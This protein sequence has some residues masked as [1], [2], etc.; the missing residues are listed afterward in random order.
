MISVNNLSLYFGGQ[1]VFKGISLSVNKGDKIGLVGKNGAGKSTLLNLFAQKIN[2]NSGNVAS[3]NNLKIGY[4]TQDLDFVD[5]LSV[6]DEAKKAYKEIN[7]LQDEIVTL[8]QELGNRTDYESEGY[9]QLISHLHEKQEQFR[10]KG[11]HD[12]Q[13]SIT[14]VLLGLGFL[15][16]DFNRLTNEFSGGWRMRIELAKILLQRPDVLLLDEPTNHLD[17]ESIIWLENWLKKF[18]GALVLVSHDRLFL[19]SVT[20]RTVEI[21]FGRLNQYK[22][23]YTKYI[24]LRKDRQ[25]KQIQAKKNQDK[26]IDETKILINKFRAK[27]NKAAF[28]QTL[29]KKLEKLEIIEVEQEDIAK[30]RFKFP[31]APHSGKVSLQ[32]K[33]ICKNYDFLSVL[34]DVNLEIV[35]GEKIAFVGKNGEGKTTLAKI[36]VDQIPF[37][38]KV[39]LGHQVN[40]GYYAQNQTDFLDEDKSVLQCIQDAADAET[41]GKVRD[42]LGSFLFSK[43][44]VDKKI[45]VLSGGE[46]AR[47]AL[48]K[49]LLEPKNLLIM[50]EPT[51]HLDMMS[52]D[53]L[54][55]ALQAYDGTLI[56]VSHDR[57]FLHE[58]TEKVY[59]FKDKNIR[60]YIG[61]INAFLKERNLMDFKQLEQKHKKESK[62]DKT[63]QQSSYHQ[64]KDALKAKR[65]LQNKISKL[66]KQIQNLEQTQ[67]KLD[68]KLADPKQFQELSKEK[69]FFEKYEKNQLKLAKMEQDWEKYIEDLEQLKS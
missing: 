33:S 38:G 53:I 62:N 3:P 15:Q 55:R 7:I 69:G 5:G 24:T 6:I 13:S 17:I 54:K 43:D 63:K 46:R 18:D 23:S 35:K 4:L 48:C 8:N 42:I 25:E 56:I 20:N 58:L 37:D 52:K 11:G 59:E 22:A 68:E 34:K 47:V 45:K 29:I 57:D 51:N 49:L 19:D 26:F 44:D 50:D 12:L 31:P 66:E 39:K 41:S 30:M 40:I 2:P 61:D 9:M 32:A 60:Q 27:K 10:L 36:L 64:Q 28:A 1:D 21:A 14:Q 16:S 67:K 65:K